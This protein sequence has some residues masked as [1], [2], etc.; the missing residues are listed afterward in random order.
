MS[1]YTPATKA[2]LDVTDVRIAV[3]A[4]EWNSHITGA[5]SDIRSLAAHRGIAF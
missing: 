2:D 1:T 4:A 3:V 5:L